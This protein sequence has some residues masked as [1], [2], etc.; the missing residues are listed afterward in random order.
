[1]FKSATFWIIVAFIIAVAVYF[2]IQVKRLMNYCF[3]LATSKT[4][5]HQATINSVDLD[6]FI[7]FKNNSNIDIEV[8]AYNFNIDLNGIKIAN[9]KS[10]KKQVV[11]AGQFTD[12]MISIDIVPK[13]VMKADKAKLIE[14]GK[15]FIT[16]KSKIVFN[17]TGTVT[18]GALGVKA[19]DVPVSVPYT[20]KEMLEPSTEEMPCL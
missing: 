4:K 8:D 10:N 5:V 6:Y 19:K 9:V 16:D 14:L 15:Y 11:K 20:L 7:R 17:T 2:G 12:F 3:T 18:A 1:M 13:D